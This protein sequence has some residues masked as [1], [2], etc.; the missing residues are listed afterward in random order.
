LSQKDAQTLR[1]RGLVDISPATY[2]R[3]RDPEMP[4]AYCP[5]TLAAGPAPIQKN[6]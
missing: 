6:A 3:V 2:C 5:N 4:L 1:L